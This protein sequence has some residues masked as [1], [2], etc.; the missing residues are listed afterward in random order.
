MQLDEK[1]YYNYLSIKSNILRP[2]DKFMSQDEMH[3]VCNSFIFKKKFFTIPF[4]LTAN[5][6]EI[7]NINNGLV[8][9]YF[10]KI[11]ITKLK[12]L[13]VSSFDK[14]KLINKIFK[15]NKKH[16]YAEFIK[17]SKDYI[18]ETES[19]ADKKK[20]PIK[21]NLVGFATRNIPHRGHEKIVLNTSLKKKVMI[22]INSDISK[23][24]KINANLSFE[25]YKKFIK[26]EKITKKITLKKIT[27]PSFL[28]G[29]RQAALHALIGKNLGCGNF[30]IGRDH[31]GYKN[32]Y[33]EFESFKFCKKHEKKIELKIL[34]S[35]SPR[36]CYGCKKVI[37]RGECKCKNKSFDISSSLIRSLKDK[38][39]IK[40]M[41]N[42]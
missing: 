37:F 13:S 19:F 6:K 42:F 25:A 29:Y 27:L 41:S 8:D 12:V 38:K 28:L 2:L 30:I 16:P 22:I 24:K 34:P 32:F 40:L 11:F 26:R 7:K 14:R 20:Y 10:K 36:Y 4:F 17:N 15:K 21:K 31:S 23:N 39:K 9:I 35:G 1:T 5:S 33:T 3:E 18:V